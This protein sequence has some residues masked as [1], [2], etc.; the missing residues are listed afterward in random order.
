MAKTNRNLPV[1]A[2][3]FKTLGDE[4]RLRIL[5]ELRSGPQN[6]TAL[7]RKLR[8]PQP[9]VSHHLALLRMAALV[10][11]TRKG[12]SVIYAVD[13]EP[14]RYERALRAVAGGPAGLRLG[15]AVLGLAKK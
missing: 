10:T 2:Q 3:L 14:V 7:V 12:K 11:A 13:A 6:V 4:T 9:S 1:L 8:M 15:K 5:M